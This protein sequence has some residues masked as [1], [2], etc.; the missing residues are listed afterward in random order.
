M[1]LQIDLLTVRIDRHLACAFTLLHSIAD[2]VD[3]ALTVNKCFQVTQ[4]RHLNQMKKHS[5]CNG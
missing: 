4:L 2:F 3:F 5:C 1:L